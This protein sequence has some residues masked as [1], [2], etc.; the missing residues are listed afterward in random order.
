[1][2]WT[3]A[4]V[5]ELCRKIEAVCPAAG[6]HVALTGGTLYKDGARKDADILF[7]RIRQVDEIDM[8]LLEEELGKIGVQMRAGNRS[9]WVIK[10]DYRKPGQ[11]RSKGLD[12]FFP[13]FDGKYGEQPAEP[14]S[15]FDQLP[16]SCCANEKRSINGGC[17]NC[18]DPCL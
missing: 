13:D 17:L 4:E 11:L 7:Y 9:G 15:D 12:L 1:M 8:E 14:V 10:A 18:G 5:I 16:E 3:Q 6:C 2:N